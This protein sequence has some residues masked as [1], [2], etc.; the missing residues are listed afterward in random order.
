MFRFS[1]LSMIFLTLVSVRLLWNVYHSS[2]GRSLERFDE[3]NLE[4]YLIDDIFSLLINIYII[5]QDIHIYML[6]IAGQTAEPNGLKIFVDTH[7]R[8][9]VLKVKSTI[10]VFKFF[11]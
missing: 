6:P 4:S 2:P 3:F 1:C 5:K 11:I 10:F 7:G 8:P 9:M